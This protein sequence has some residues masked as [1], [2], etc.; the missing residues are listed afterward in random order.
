MWNYGEATVA[1]TPHIGRGSSLEQPEIPR[2]RQEEEMWWPWGK[3]DVAQVVETKPP[4][5]VDNSEKVNLYAHINQ[6]LIELRAG[7]DETRQQFQEQ[8]KEIAEL[9]RKLDQIYL[10]TKARTQK[11]PE[12]SEATKAVEPIKGQP[13]KKK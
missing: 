9:S 11:P 1:G 3:E 4:S 10:L 7:R 6:M 13:H 12:P 5:G 2:G 8:R